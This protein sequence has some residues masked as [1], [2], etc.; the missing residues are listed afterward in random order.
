NKGVIDQVGS[1]RDV[2]EQPTTR[3][4]AQFI[5]ETNTVM[6]GGKEVLV[7]PEHTR[8]V[9]DA[10]PS[11]FRGIVRE[12]TFAGPIKTAVVK[13]SVDDSTVL[14]TSTSRIEDHWTI[15]QEVGIIFDHILTTVA[16]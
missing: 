2:Y 14:A 15:G 10:E 4:V 11:S 13:L 3:F 1:P 9:A 8:I 7:R 6:L 16:S 12:I 5:G